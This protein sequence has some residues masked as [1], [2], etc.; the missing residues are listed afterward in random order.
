MTEAQFIIPLPGG[1]AHPTPTPTT[2]T[3][4]TATPTT[5]APTTSPVVAPTN[6]PTALPA[7]LAPAPLPTTLAP[8]Q[9]PTPVAL[10]ATVAPTTAAPVAPEPTAVTLAPAVAIEPTEA[11]AVAATETPAV[12][13]TE[14]PAVPTTTASIAPTPS[15]SEFPICN[16]CGDGKE[17]GNPDGLALDDT[18]TC[19]A[20]AELGAKG[21]LEPV[22][23]AKVAERI[24]EDCACK[25]GEGEGEPIE[26]QVVMTLFSVSSQMPPEITQQF[27]DS[28]AQFYAENPPDTSRNYSDWSARII[29]QNQVKEEARRHHRLRHLQEGNSTLFPLL[30]RTVMSALVQGEQNTSD[31]QERL[32][33]TIDANM[34]GFTGILNTANSDY[35]SSVETVETSDTNST[36]PAPA[37]NSTTPPSPAPPTPSSTGGGLSTG[38]IV[39]IAVG[40]LAAIIIIALVIKQFSSEEGDPAAAAAAARAARTDEEQPRASAAAV[41]A[42]SAGKQAS[43][44]GMSSKPKSKPNMHTVT[45]EIVA[46][47]GTLGLVLDTMEGRGPIVHRVHVDSPMAGKIFK[48]DVIVAVSGVDTRSMNA[49]HVTKIMHETADTERTLRIEREEPISE[50]ELAAIAAASTGASVAAAATSPTVVLH[51][52]MA[53]KGKLGIILDTVEGKGPIVHRVHS[54]S[55]L[56]GKVFEGD[57]IAFINGID[58]RP[59]DATKIT[60]IMIETAE[61]ERL[62]VVERVHKPPKM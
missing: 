40:V 6:P 43:S 11:P 22:Q 52:I 59:M 24:Q 32:R 50:T 47:P 29:S 23:C 34:T 41:A 36:T 19:S 27:E 26:G 51:E 17:V 9:L 37:P 61:N 58:T 49:T 2:A 38:A 31:F 7:T 33:E 35:F 14:A 60:A 21:D 25:G 46:P 57:I 10:P 16:V 3:P 54:E 4:T 28:L 48:K 55:P 5:A 62:L 13:A 8:T 44:I 1:S 15:S 20:L 12:A 30:T 18:I 45:R 42:A 53:P 56:K 39:G